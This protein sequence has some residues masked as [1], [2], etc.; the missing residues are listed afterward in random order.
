MIDINKITQ[1]L[2]WYAIKLTGNDDDATDLM[3]DTLIKTL[4]AQWKPDNEPDMETFINWY[5]QTFE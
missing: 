1:S 3:Q 5:Q 2:K 4:T